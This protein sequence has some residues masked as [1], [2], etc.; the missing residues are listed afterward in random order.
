VRI[1]FH[2]FRGIGWEEEGGELFADVA[3]ATAG[4]STA[5]FLYGTLQQW[6]STLPNQV[7]VDL[8]DKGEGAQGRKGGTSRRLGGEVAGR[9]RPGFP[10]REEKGNAASFGFS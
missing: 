5:S 7:L 3:L 4:V 6:G 1:E 9:R 10:G 8:T 2:T